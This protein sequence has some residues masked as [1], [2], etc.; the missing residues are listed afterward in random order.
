MKHTGAA[1]FGFQWKN[2]KLCVV[3]AEALIRR[4]AFELYQKLRNK[5]AVAKRLNELGHRTRRDGEWRDVTVA[6][7]L[8]CSSAHGLYAVNKTSL[9]AAGERVEKPQDQWDFVPCPPIVSPE[10]W[11][12][13]QGILALETPARPPSPIPSHPFTGVLFCRC[14]SRMNAATSSPKY[15][16]AQCGNRIPMSD[17]KTAFLDEV[18]SFL[19]ARRQTA[20]E[21]ITSDPDLAAQRQLLQR[22]Q[23]TARKIEDEIAKAERLY[24]ENR[25]SVERFEKLHHPLEDQRRAIQAELGRIKTKLARVESKQTTQTPNPPFDPTALRER[26]PQLPAKMRRQIVVSFLDRIVV[27]ADEL[28][29]SY[30]FRDSS[31]RAAKAQHSPGPTNSTGGAALTAADPLIRSTSA[32]QSPE[33]NAHSPA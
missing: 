9:T 33:S 18:T 21:V 3:E 31:E 28:E 2:D 8:S 26:W 10:L 16:C 4:M 6:R 17:L 15:V 13:V 32:F 23:D 1:P 14:G 20:A 7:L 27:A 12:E 5:A 29:F 19:Q 11:E 24:M 30:R 22:T 25:I